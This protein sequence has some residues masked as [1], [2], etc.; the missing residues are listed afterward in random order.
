MKLLTLKSLDGH[1]NINVCKYG[2]WVSLTLDNGRFPTVRWF[3]GKKETLQRSQSV[4]FKLAGVASLWTLLIWPLMLQWY[5]A[6]FMR[7]RETGAPW[8]YSRGP[9][10]VTRLWS[11]ESSKWSERDWTR[12]W[13]TRFCYKLFPPTHISQTRYGSVCIDSCFLCIRGSDNFLM[14]CWQNHL[15]T[16]MH[17]VFCRC[18]LSLYW[19]LSFLL[20]IRWRRHFPVLHLKYLGIK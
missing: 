19:C 18:F 6:Y 14:R 4:S 2:T 16:V 12:Y 11:S 10:P 13:W 15:G 7:R 3:W 17:T 5:S 8:F 1:I 9:R 20:D